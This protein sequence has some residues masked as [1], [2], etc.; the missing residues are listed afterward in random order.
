VAGNNDRFRIDASEFGGGL[1][2]GGT[3]AASQFRT[4]ADNVAQDA[5]DRFVLRTT[6]ATLWFD[7]N[8]NARE[9]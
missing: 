4:R 5:N 8:G 3:L 1:A 9:G 7:S 6:D 2:A